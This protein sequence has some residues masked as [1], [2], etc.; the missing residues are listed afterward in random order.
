MINISPRQLEVFVG[1]AEEG[2]VRAAAE[3][4]YLTQPAASM[5]L[6]EL[7]HRLDA[8][9]FARDRGRLHLNERGRELLPLAR[10]ILKRMEE[11]KRVAA[12]EPHQLGGE[13]RLGA[14]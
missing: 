2:S 8:P 3:R 6:G 1:V 14:S 11:V 7:E 5:A 10:E 9:L 4:L 12:D 13:L